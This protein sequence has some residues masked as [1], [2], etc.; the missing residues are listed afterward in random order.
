MEARAG[1]LLSRA[2]RA[3]RAV[4]A[5]TGGTGDAPCA[6]RPRRTRPSGIIYRRC[7]FSSIMFSSAQPSGHQRPTD[8]WSSVLRKDH[9]TSIPGRAQPVVA[10]S[11]EMRCWSCYGWKMPR[12][13]RATKAPRNS[14]NAVAG[15]KDVVPHHSVSFYAPNPGL[16]RHVR[17]R[18]GSTV[19]KPCRDWYFRLRS[20]SDWKSRCGA[21]LKAVLQ[22]RHR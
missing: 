17:F 19:P 10:S 14:L 18:R 12:Q 5:S 7:L 15:R 13:P 20:T 22:R 11:F 1:G 4:S 21:T 16:P 6:S 3:D 8:Y 9:R 2:Q